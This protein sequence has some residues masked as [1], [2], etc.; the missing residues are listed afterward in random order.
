MISVQSSSESAAKTSGQVNIG[1][2][3]CK[4]IKEK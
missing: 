4:K 2:S 1:L 3:H